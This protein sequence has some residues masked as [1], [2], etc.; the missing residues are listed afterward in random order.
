VIA[1]SQKAKVFLNY[2]DK[3]WWRGKKPQLVIVPEDHR[4]SK[5]WVVEQLCHRLGK[6]YNPTLVGKFTIVFN[7]RTKRDFKPHKL[8]THDAQH[9]LPVSV[10][11]ICSTA[12]I[13]RDDPC[14]GCGNDPL[15]GAINDSA[16]SASPAVT[17]GPKERFDPFGDNE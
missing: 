2:P 11:C 17:D 9:R 10:C 1:T 5:E 13:N 8:T 14:P 4:D 6:R 7:E 12:I 16:E 3:R 15:T